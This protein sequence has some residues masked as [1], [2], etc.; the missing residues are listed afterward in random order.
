MVSFQGEWGEGSLSQTDGCSTEN[1]KQREAAKC[2]SGI[3]NEN[4]LKGEAKRQ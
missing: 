1:R 2:L 3:N 4:D